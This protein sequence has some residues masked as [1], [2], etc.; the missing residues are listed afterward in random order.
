MKQ[1]F[2]M[3]DFLYG[4]KSAIQSKNRANIDPVFP[5]KFTIYSP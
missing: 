5:S 4:I 2:R 3:M 1:E